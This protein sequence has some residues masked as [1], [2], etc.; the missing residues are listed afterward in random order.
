ML[1]RVKLRLSLAFILLLCAS[2]DWQKFVESFAPKRD[3]ELSRHCFAL[4]QSRDFA[5]LEAAF[6]PVQRGPALRA[7]LEAAAARIPAD[8]P[9]TREIVSV[10]T[11]ITNGYATVFITFRYQYPEGWREYGYNAA[12]QGD[13]RTVQWLNI[14]IIPP[15]EPWMTM[16]LEPVTLI[17]LAIWV[18][19]MII[20][21]V[22]IYRLFIRKR[23]G[24]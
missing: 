17:G 19:A 13:A 21:L 20:A 22:V 10:N 3:L 14:E 11:S 2:C 8:A 24:R 6:D 23:L 18:A 4:L 16:L 9:I 12:G 7:K 15:P 5:A 1:R